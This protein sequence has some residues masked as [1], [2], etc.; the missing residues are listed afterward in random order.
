MMDAAGSDCGHQLPP[1]HP[2]QHPGVRVLLGPPCRSGRLLLV[3]GSHPHGQ[4][5]GV[6]NLL[7][8]GAD[9]C[10]AQVEKVGVN[11]SPVPAA[12]GVPVGH[13]TL[14]PAHCISR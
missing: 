7:F 3:P 2:T 9:H 1:L 11:S 4:H 8:F 13:P 14:V 5:K 6:L 12:S 10:F